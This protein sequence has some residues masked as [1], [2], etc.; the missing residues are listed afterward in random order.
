MH[1]YFLHSIFWKLIPQ[2]LSNDFW[3]VIAIFNQ[4]LADIFARKG[5]FK[6]ALTYLKKGE[7]IANNMGD[8]EMTSSLLFN[9]SLVY[10]M[11]KDMDTAVKSFKRSEEIAFPL[12]SPLEKE[13]RRNA[14]LHFAKEN[15]LSEIEN[16]I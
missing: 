1:Y 10:L 11:M 3:W 14:V 6:K 8:L 5:D 4:N 15:S 16:M 12:P 9:F 13:E 2:K 7:K